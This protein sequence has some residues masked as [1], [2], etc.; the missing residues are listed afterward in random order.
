M[1]TRRDTPRGPML[2]LPTNIRVRYR[3]PRKDLLRGPQLAPSTNSRVR[4]RS[5]QPERQ[6]PNTP[7]PLQSIGRDKLCQFLLGNSQHTL[8]PKSSCRLFVMP[9]FAS[10]LFYGTNLR[11]RDL[12]I[13]SLSSLSPFI[14]CDCILFLNALDDFALLK[15]QFTEV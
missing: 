15:L 13:L 1:L 14:Y 3:P 4:S 11:K 2:D 10:S 8:M 12:K 5:Y 9:L 7:C 6:G